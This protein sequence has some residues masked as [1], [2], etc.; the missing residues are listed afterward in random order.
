M[1]LGELIEA[2][3]AA[4]QDLVLPDGFNN[5]HSY[6]GFYEDLAFEPAKDVSVRDMRLAAQYALNSTFQGWKG[7][8]FTMNQFTDCWLANEGSGSGETIGALFLQLM[9]ERGRK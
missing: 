5:P 9:L 3:E 1:M 4:D 8:N 2:L 7:G 6:R